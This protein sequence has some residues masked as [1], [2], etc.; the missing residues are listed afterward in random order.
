[1]PDAQRNQENISN[2]LQKI[3]MIE[4]IISIEKIRNYGGNGSKYQVENE[5]F[6]A[7]NF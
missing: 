1:M 7:G 4:I 6:G 2:N 5:N 3:Q